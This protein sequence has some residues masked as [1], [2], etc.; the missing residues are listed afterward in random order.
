MKS[1]RIIG[2][3]ILLLSFLPIGAQ[4]HA[5]HLADQ[6]HIKDADSGKVL[7]GVYVNNYLKNNEYFYHM[8][9]GYT[10]FGTQLRTVLAYVPNKH[11]RIEGGVYLKKDFGK[12]DFS[13]VLPLISMKI[14]KNGYSAIVGNLEGAMNHDLI[15][16][17][18]DYERTITHFYEN[19]IQFKADKKRFQFD[20][21]LDWVTKETANTYSQEELQAGIGTK[22]TLLEKGKLKLIL[23]VQGV[24]WHRGGQLSL[25]ASP[26]ESLANSAIGLRLELNSEK[27]K[28]IKNMVAETYYVRYDHD[29]NASVR[30]WPDGMGYFSNITM[31][32]KPGFFASASYWFGHH[33]L[34]NMGGD[35]YQSISQPYSTYYQNYRQLILFRLGFIKEI[36]PGTYVDIRLEPYYDIE[37]SLFEFSYSGYLTFKKDFSFKRKQGTGNREQGTD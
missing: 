35:L 8:V 7:V 21:W 32:T 30:R 11:M 1:L 12:D 36:L 13:R 33:Y 37:N 2:F 10:L 25:N 26:I 14:Q 31:R 5:P 29:K 27:D 24:V 22:I 20:G 9:H 15:E 28:F 16:P 19:G 34:T 23:P 17:L 3:S 4:I 6:I 18:F